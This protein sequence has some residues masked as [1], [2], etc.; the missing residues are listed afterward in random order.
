MEFRNKEAKVTR[1]LEEHE[2]LRIVSCADEWVR[3][4]IMV[5][6]YTGLRLSNVLNLTWNQVDFIGKWIQVEQTKNGEAVKIPICGPLLDTLKYLNRVRRLHDNHVFPYDG[7]FDAFKL[8]VQRA[9]K[10]AHKVAG[11]EWLRAFHDYRHFFISFLVN[12][13]VNLAVVAELAGHN[14]LTVTKRYS[15]INDKAKREAVSSFGSSEWDGTEPAKEKV[16]CQTL[17]K[18]FSKSL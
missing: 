8:R 17:A 6:L 9:C 15:H 2:A 12:R 1:F 4:I 13:N 7:R 16:S 14:N 5:G 10:R 18:G 3:P 11:F